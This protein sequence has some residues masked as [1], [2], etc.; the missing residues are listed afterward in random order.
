MIVIIFIFLICLGLAL[1]G[2]IFKRKWTSILTCLPLIVFL[3]G[4]A[5]FYAKYQTGVHHFLH[6]LSPPKNLYQPLFIDDLFL[7]EKGFSKE[8][9]LEPKYIDIYDIGF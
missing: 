6:M 3:T 7:W 4:Y 8:F 9:F 5:S 1:Y 2:L